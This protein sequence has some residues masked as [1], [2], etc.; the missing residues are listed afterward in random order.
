[1]RPW[2]PGPWA[3][4]GASALVLSLRVAS[5]HRHAPRASPVNGG[6]GDHVS[7]ASGCELQAVEAAGAPTLL[8]LVL[9]PD[10]TKSYILLGPTSW[11]S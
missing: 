6:Q 2:V 7:Q 5:V 10:P 8:C 9:P 4:L 3:P 11:L 1:M